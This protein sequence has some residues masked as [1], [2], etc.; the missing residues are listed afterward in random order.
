[1]KEKASEQQK[2]NNLYYSK[3]IINQKG[4]PR[5]AKRIKKEATLAQAFKLHTDRKN[6]M[7]Q[8]VSNGKSKDA[9]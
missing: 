6:R 7:G 5:D 3:Q 2:H 4:D 1:M 8:A 9:D